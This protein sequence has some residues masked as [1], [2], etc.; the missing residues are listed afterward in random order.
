MEGRDE[1]ERGRE[2]GIDFLLLWG[3]FLRLVCT[4]NEGTSFSF[5]V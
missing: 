2:E 4:S 5:D 3:A 1:R